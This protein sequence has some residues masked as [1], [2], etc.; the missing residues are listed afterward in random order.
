[1]LLESLQQQGRELL[2]QIVVLHGSGLDRFLFLRAMSP[3]SPPSSAVEQVAPCNTPCVKTLL[4][5]EIFKGDL[6]VKQK[7]MTKFSNKFQS[8]ICNC[9]EK[10]ISPSPNSCHWLNQYLCYP[11]MLGV[12]SGRKMILS[13]FNCKS[14]SLFSVTFPIPNIISKSLTQD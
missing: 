6:K 9:A 4:K 1:M 14:D 3:V 12:H 11:I 2:A 7:M 5:M 10:H 13:T 8:L